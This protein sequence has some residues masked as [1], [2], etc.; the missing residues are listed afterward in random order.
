M[1]LIQE[2]VHLKNYLKTSEEK[3][4]EKEN[5]KKI[6]TFFNHKNHSKN[7]NNQ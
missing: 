2:S 3:V 4:K 5:I 7:K 6:F 1:E